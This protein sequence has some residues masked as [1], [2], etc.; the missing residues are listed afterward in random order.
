M[1]RVAIFGGGVAGLSAAHELGERGFAVEVFEKKPLFGGKARSLS[2][3]GTATGARRDLPG[4]HG[5]RFFPGFYRHLP[6]TMSRIPFG[7]GT[8]V[9]D[10]LTHATRILLAR[11]GA[12]PIDLP[13]RLPRDTQD[14][15]IA[16]H[17][18][19][20]GIGIPDDEVLYFI[21]RL[22][23]LLTTCP[24]RRLREYEG[25]SWWNFI[26]AA[27]RSLPYQTM[28]AQGLTRSLVALRAEEGSTRTVGYTLLQLFAG[29]ISPDGFDRLL[30]GPTS[31]VWIGPWVEYLKSRNVVFH[32]GAMAVSF[33]LSAA[34]VD[35]VVVETAAGR[36]TVRA[37]YYLAALPVEVMSPLISPDVAK[38]APSLAGIGRL[39][40]RWMNGIQ[41]YLR[42]DVPLGYGHTVY[43]GSPWA[44]TSISQK[45][46]WTNAPLEDFG[47][48]TVGGILSV[49]ISEW[50]KPGV[51]F[52]KPANAC[53]A[54]EIAKDV[55]A[56]LKL[57]LNI[58]AGIV[59]DDSNLLSWFLDPDIE[60]PNQSGVSNQEPLLVNTIN[61]LQ[62]RPDAVTEIPNLFLASDY[63]RTFTDVACMEAANEAARRAVNGI[64]ARSGSSA[65]VTLW[66]LKEPDVFAPFREYDQVRLSL[67]LPHASFAL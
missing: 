19:L 45:Q 55:W 13:A 43:T 61:S 63:V 66:P 35:G 22:L 26:G 46:F 37:D 32:S 25:I 16:L 51:L 30:T 65:S 7:A 6:D 21:E 5:F 53:T 31:E 62:Y 18:M 47:T 34:G 48:G 36:G 49:D 28:L 52:G 60:F 50:E 9:A 3:P 24:K 38:G 20:T 10:N 42:T 1:Q 57:H 14:W 44:L 40:K 59:I 15:T 67:G 39:E 64:L 8:S 56:Q 27:T 12:P 11:T 33:G 4:E 17:A 29:I 58:G 2:V 41:F 23:V 54:D